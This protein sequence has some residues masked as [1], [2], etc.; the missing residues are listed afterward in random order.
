LKDNNMKYFN[1]NFFADHKQQCEQ[2]WAIDRYALAKQI[3]AR[4]PH[5]TG[6][7]ICLI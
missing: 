6:I 3:L 4:Y 7:Y 1:V 2:I 5:A